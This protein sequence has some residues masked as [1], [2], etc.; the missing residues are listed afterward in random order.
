MSMSTSPQISGVNQL[1]AAL[2][3]KEY[4]R[5]LPHWETVPLDFKQVLYVPGESIE[6]VYFPNSGIVSLLIIMSD[7]VAAEVGMVG[8]EG[9]AG[10]PVFLG[11]DTIP[12]Q[13]IVQVPGDCM[14]MKADIFKA[15]VNPSDTLHGLLQRYAHALIVQASQLVACKSHHSMQQRCCRWLLMTHDRAGTNQFPITHEFLSKM[16]GVRRATVTEVANTLQKAG[17]I[18]YSRGQL[19]VQDRLGLESA[20]CE[21][22]QKVKAE[23]D[24]LSV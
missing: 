4:N 1:L 17:L 3:R 2:P 20:A 12:N 8:N 16:M 11:V 24:R 9:M 13:A 7:S 22:Y 21:C 23:F 19:T 15:S 5:L 6:Y 14:R 18:R 10:L